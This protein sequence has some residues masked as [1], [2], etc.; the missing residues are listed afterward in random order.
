VAI[1]SSAPIRRAQRLAEAAPAQR[2]AAVAALATGIVLTAAEILL[3]DWQAGHVAAGAALGT[4]IWGA[5]Q[6]L[7]Y[8]AKL[9]PRGV[10]QDAPRDV[11]VEPQ[12]IDLSSGFWLIGLATLCVP[13]A[14]LLDRLAVGAVFIPGQ[15]F[16]YAAASLI[17]LA[18]ITRW[19]RANRRRVLFEP[20][21]D[22]VRP[23]AS[24]PV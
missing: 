24:P 1:T 12:G 2:T 11:Q 14:W 8:T 16:G 9:V 19:E 23:Y 20:D 4:C 15:P 10:P 18:R 17:G 5:T 3:F 21:T 22:D 13:L 7:R 6:Y